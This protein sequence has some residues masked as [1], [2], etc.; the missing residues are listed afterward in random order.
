[1]LAAAASR[2]VARRASVRILLIALLKSMRCE[3]VLH[4]IQASRQLRS[5]L[6]AMIA[7]RALKRDRPRFSVAFELA[8]HAK[9]SARS[10]VLPDANVEA[11][12][13]FRDAKT[14]RRSQTRIALRQ[15]RS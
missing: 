7:R 3:S 15:D 10:N 2:R 9:K 1:M 14:V 13:F 8:R 4:R 5:A 11:R 6:L 12:L